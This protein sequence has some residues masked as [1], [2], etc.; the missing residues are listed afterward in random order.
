MFINSLKEYT[1]FSPKFDTQAKINGVAKTF[2]SFNRWNTVEREPVVL[3]CWFS[4]F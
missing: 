4:W 1:Q 2:S 3:L